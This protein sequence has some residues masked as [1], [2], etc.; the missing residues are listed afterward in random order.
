MQPKGERL[1]GGKC[2]FNI[3]GKQS[4]GIDPRTPFLLAVQVCNAIL[5]L[6]V[7]VAGHAHP[8]SSS[9]SLC[10]ASTFF[11]SSCGSLSQSSAASPF[12]GD[13]LVPCQ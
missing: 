12:R 5:K 10:L 1:G 13:A 7:C 11:F 2:R 9:T 4:R 8:Y 6:G 3:D